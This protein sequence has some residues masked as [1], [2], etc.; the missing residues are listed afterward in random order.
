MARGEDVHKKM[1]PIAS[2]E[3]VVVDGARP[4]ASTPQLRTE[5]QDSDNLHRVKRQGHDELHVVASRVTTDRGLKPVACESEIFRHL[6]HLHIRGNIFLGLRTENKSYII[7][8]TG[9]ATYVVPRIRF[10][11]H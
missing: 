8:L 3:P 1:S 10:D 4:I 7:E 9:V 5:K 11:R 6:I 2:N